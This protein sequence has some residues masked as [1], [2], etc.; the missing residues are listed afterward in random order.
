MTAL[1]LAAGTLFATSPDT[2]TA[3]TGQNVTVGGICIGASPTYFWRTADGYVNPVYS[4]AAMNWDNGAGAHHAIDGEVYALGG[5]AGAGIRGTAATVG[6]FGVLAEHKASAGTALRVNGVASFSRSGRK[7]ILKGR[8]GATVTGL[9]HVGTDALILA[10]LQGSAGAG[11]YV[12]YA[13]R[14]SDTSFKVA[15]AKAASSTVSFAWL[16][17]G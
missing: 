17:L 5:A 11:N 8:S 3:A 16:I 1:V 13:Q 15:L 4:Q 10:T 9:S 7:T 12:R 2:V 14:V 6:Q